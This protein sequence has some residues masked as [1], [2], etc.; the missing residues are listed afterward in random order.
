MAAI[1]LE[2]GG[3]EDQAIAALL[4]DAVEDQGGEPTLRIIRQQFGDAVADI[5]DGCTDT[6]ETPK[7]PWKQRKLDY[8]AHLPSAPPSVLLVAAAD[9][10]ANARSILVDH[11]EAGEQLWRRFSASKDETLWYYRSL[12]EVIRTAS[13]GALADELDRT[14]SE[15]ERL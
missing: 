11:R 3:T 7:P 6:D 13:P 1:V 5:V 4:H 10:L 9:K 2:Y 8:L 15:M 14:V 12:A